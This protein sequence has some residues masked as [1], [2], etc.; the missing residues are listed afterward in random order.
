MLIKIS[1]SILHQSE[2]Q[3]WSISKQKNLQQIVLLG[4]NKEQEK[5]LKEVRLADRMIPLRKKMIK[6]TTNDKINSAGEFI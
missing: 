2:G 3:L 5:K 1:N 6:F 4:P